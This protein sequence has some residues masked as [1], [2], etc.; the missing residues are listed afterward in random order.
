MSVQYPFPIFVY[1]TLRCN[2]SCSYC[3]TFS[4]PA[5]AE[6][7]FLLGRWEQFLAACAELGIPEVRLSGG[8]PLLIDDI[9]QRCK[10]ILDRGMR[11]TILTNGSLLER[12]LGW[13]SDEPP[14]TI[15][16]SYHREFSS[17]D[18]F[19]RRISRASEVLACVGVHVISCDVENDST[20]VDRA[21]GGL[22]P[23]E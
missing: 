23:S 14:E 1:P 2:F 3:F 18:I 13:L 20:L 6:G 10:T 8:E 15:W 7:S 16:I 9:R 11:Y 19:E 4:G 22:V 5:E 17:A 12:H 21:V